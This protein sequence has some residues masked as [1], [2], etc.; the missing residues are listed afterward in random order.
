MGTDLHIADGAVMAIYFIVV[1]TVGVIAGKF[2][3]TTNDFFFGGQRFRWWLIGISCIATLVGSYSFRQYSETGYK[4]GFC[5]MMPYT[6]EWFVLPLFLLGWLPI[7]YYSRV[8]SIPEYFERRFDQKTRIA[9]L[10]VLLLYLEVYIGINLLTIGRIL[11]AVVGIDMLGLI[12]FENSPFATEAN[13]MCWAAL[14]AIASGIYLH[15]GGQTSVLMT[16]LLQGLLLLSVGLGLFALGL[17]EL[18]GLGTLWEGMRPVQRQPLAPFNDPPQLHAVGDFWNDAFVGTFAFYLINQGILMRFLC[19]RSVD[20]GRKAML[21]VVVLMMPLAAIAVSG[22]G[23]V[24]WSLDAHD[25]ASGEN[26]DP[27]VAAAVAGADPE[28]AT[29]EQREAFDARARDIFVTVARRICSIRGMFGLVIA[30]V[31]AALMSTLDTYIAAVSAIAVNDIWRP[32]DPGRDD[33]HYLQAAKWTAVVATLVGLA[34][35]PL[36][37]QYDSIYQAISFF[38]SA[39]IPPLAV[40]IL[41]ALCWPR[42]SSRGAFVT[43]VLGTGA[44]IVSVIEP[45]LIIPFAHGV[46][47]VEGAAGYLQFPYMRGFYGLIVS[48]IVAVVVT[49]LDPRKPR[50][51][52]PGLMLSTIAQGRRIFKG[53]EPCDRGIG[54]KGFVERLVVDERAG[55]GVQVPASIREKLELKPGDLLH[56]ADSRRWLGGLRSVQLPVAE[57]PC[58]EGTVVVSPASLEKGYLIAGKRT[59]LE[60]IM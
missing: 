51:L 6:N 55:G 7:I 41:C 4:F 60:K 28:Q 56:V 20:E 30:A 31:I 17:Y 1:V 14:M 45:R 38:T 9:V 35:I 19:A 8:Q 12:G 22:A 42:F 34:L 53:G 39:I 10:V 33:K 13:I 18:G 57:E 5:S 48:G 32:L 44:M 2:T 43:M 16:D 26:T 36:A 59:R 58:E 52:D 54:R 29:D 49:L 15:A 25:V 50:D 46:Q 3:S 47:M 40:V 37:E 23:W 24:G 27:A 11:N 21:F